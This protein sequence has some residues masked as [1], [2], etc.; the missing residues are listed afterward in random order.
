MLLCMCWGSTCI[1][2]MWRAEENHKSLSRNCCPPPLRQT[3]SLAQRP[4]IRLDLMASK[5]KNPVSTPLTVGLQN[6][7]LHPAILHNFWGLHSSPHACKA[8]DLHAMIPPQLPGNT[9]LNELRGKKTFYRLQ[10]YKSCRK[11]VE[12]IISM[13]KFAAL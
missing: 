6:M 12:T 11:A 2:T 9:L 7:L 5:P 8:S 3:L 10:K 4:L 13:L 1:C